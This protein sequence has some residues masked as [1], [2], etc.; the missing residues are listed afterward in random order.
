MLVAAQVRLAHLT[1]SVFTVPAAGGSAVLLAVLLVSAVLCVV[2]AVRAQDVRTGAAARTD[3]LARA[4]TAAFEAKSLESLTL[5]SR[6]ARTDGEQAWQ[7]AF[8]Q[9]FPPTRSVPL[10]RYRDAHEQIAELDGTGRW[11]EAVARA[12]DTGPGSA[13]AAFAQFDAASGAQ[14]DDVA[15]DADDGLAGARGPLPATAAVLALA[16]VAG[17]AGV[18]RG[19]ARRLAEY[20]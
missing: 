19:V 18:T 6:G 14:L 5:I 1:R 4:R 3:R 17:G 16:G 9:A 12:S 2:A 10:L 15:E 13:N 20:R 11:T 7:A 8:R